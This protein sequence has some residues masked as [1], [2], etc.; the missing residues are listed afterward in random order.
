MNHSATNFDYFDLIVWICVRFRIF[1]RLIFLCSR[2]E[3]H[4][5]DAQICMP[6][7]TVFKSNP[8]IHYKMHFVHLNRGSRSSCR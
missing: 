6:Y 8:N 1:T 2:K 7:T 3:M 5:V 4:I